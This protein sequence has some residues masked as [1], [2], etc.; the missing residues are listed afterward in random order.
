MLIL[1]ITAGLFTIYNYNNFAVT[2]DG[3]YLIA[4]NWEDKINFYNTSTG[5]IDYQL[6]ALDVKRVSKDN[7]YQVDVE[8]YS[9]E[10]TVDLGSYSMWFPCIGVVNQ[11]GTKAFISLSTNNSAFIDFTTSSINTFF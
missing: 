9:L 3:V 2:N 8:T 7:I 1:S 5:A 11:D 6:D 4:G 10:T